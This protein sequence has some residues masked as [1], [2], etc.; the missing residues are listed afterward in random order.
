MGESAVRAFHHRCETPLHFLWLNLVEKMAN[1]P[2]MARSAP[3]PARPLTVELL[4]RF[5]LDLGTCVGHAA[6]HRI[7]IVD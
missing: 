4:L 6:N 7:G 5:A 2:A 3:L 1:V